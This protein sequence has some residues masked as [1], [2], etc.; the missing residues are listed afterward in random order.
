MKLDPSTLASQLS[1]L[2]GWSYDEA[3]GGLIAREYQF[4]DFAQATAKLYSNPMLPYSKLPYS[5]RMVAA[6]DWISL[7]K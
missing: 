7:A 3:R 5:Q 1:Q 4:A 6:S 2:D